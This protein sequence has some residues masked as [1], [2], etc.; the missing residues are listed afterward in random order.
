MN[1]QLAATNR[2]M[3]GVFTVTPDNVSKIGGIPRLARLVFRTLARVRHG[4]M[5]VTLPDGRRLLFRGTE[6]GE[7]AEIIIR[8]FGLTRRFFAGGDLGAAEAFLDGMWDSPNVTAFLQ[9]F[10]RNKDALQD[11]LTGMPVVRFLSRIGHLMRRNS[12]SGSKRN[13]EY[14][15]D[16]GNSFYDRWLD[17]TMTYSS[18]LF[19]YPDQE[20]SEA[21][22]NKYRTLA[23]NMDLRPEHHLLEI[24]S[25]WG[26]FAEFAASEIGCR[27]TGITIS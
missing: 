4:S 11:R 2:D 14:H 23:R 8:D 19:E 26:G 7:H 6:P 16:L 27:V 5:T 13:I 12:K 24:G 25:G 10:I 18:A 15:Y 3:G 9:F 1:H 21:Q 22:T 20:L 17:T